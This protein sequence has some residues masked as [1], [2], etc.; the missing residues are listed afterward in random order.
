MFGAKSALDYLVGEKS[1]TFADA[2]GDH[3]EFA[4]ELPRFL[5]AIWEMVNEYEIAGYIAIVVEQLSSGHVADRMRGWKQ[6]ACRFA[7]SRRRDP[8]LRSHVRISRP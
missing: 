4:R 5:A 2:A 7:C 3:P 6:G 8:E 1:M